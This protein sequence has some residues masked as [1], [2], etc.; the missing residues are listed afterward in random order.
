MRLTECPVPFLQ[1][2]LLG[3]VMVR[4][5]LEPSLAVSAVHRGL[6]QVHGL[7]SLL[8]MSKTGLVVILG[9]YGLLVG[10]RVRQRLTQGSHLLRVWLL[11]LAGP[12]HDHGRRVT[13]SV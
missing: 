12:G 4:I 9:R 10:R 3:I 2:H 5:P 1:N 11:G 8:L 13:A 7:C 6:S